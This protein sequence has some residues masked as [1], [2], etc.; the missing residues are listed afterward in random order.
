MFRD[1]K[2]TGVQG[3]LRWGYH[4]AAAL[5]AYTITRIDGGFAL[6]ATVVSQDAFRVSQ[7]PLV[8]EAPHEHGAWR[9]PVTTLQIDGVSLVATLGPKEKSNEH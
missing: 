9:F 2:V 4:Q 6:S 3:S 1:L 7:R 5:R 8:F